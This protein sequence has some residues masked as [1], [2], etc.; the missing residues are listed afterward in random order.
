MKNKNSLMDQLL[1][2]QQARSLKKGDE[3]EATVVSVSK[4]GVL[5]DIGAKA[6]AVLGRLEQKDLN[7]YRNY[8]KPGQ[9]IKVVVVTPE[10][11]AA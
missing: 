3:I 10:S 7:L 1:K 6:Y 2:K 4:K 11:I 9:K 5:F 8:L